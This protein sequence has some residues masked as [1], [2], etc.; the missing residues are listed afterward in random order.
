M[1]TSGEAGLVASEL[2][3]GLGARRTAELERSVAAL[4]CARV[5]QLG[6]ADSGMADAPTGHPDSFAAADVD[7]AAR[8]LADIL[9]EERADVLTTYDAAG[10]YGHP[11]HI[12][13]HL[14]GARAGELAGTPIVLAATV[15]RRPL[16]RVLQVLARLRWVIRLPGEFDPERFRAAYAGHDEIT[17]RIDVGPYISAKRAAMQAHASQAGADVGGRSLAFFLRLPKPLFRLAF[18]HEWF[19][20]AGRTPVRPLVNDVF[21]DRLNRR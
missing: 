13:V 2:R 10:G 7:V 18:R 1:A 20:Q 19:V 5:V 16:L 14:V 21:S 3:D 9:D 17:H 11:D 4:G 15:D 6:Y 12:A 8:R